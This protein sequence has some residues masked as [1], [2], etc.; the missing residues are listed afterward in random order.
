MIKI[1]LRAE[2]NNPLKVLVCA[3]IWGIGICHFLI[4]I[5]ICIYIYVVSLSH[6]KKINVL[7]NL[8]KD[9]ILLFLTSLHLYLTAITERK[10]RVSNPGSIQIFKTAG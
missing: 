8:E 5:Y 6:Y 2:I 10:V 9:M 4:Y 7:F 3:S 1:H